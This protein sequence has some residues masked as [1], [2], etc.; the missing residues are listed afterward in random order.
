MVQLI[1]LFKDSYRRRKWQP[2]PVLLPGEFHGWRNFVDY[3]PEG[4]KELDT[5][6][7]VSEWAQDIIAKEEMLRPRNEQVLRAE[8]R[9]PTMAQKRNEKNLGSCGHYWVKK[10]SSSPKLLMGKICFS[11]FK[12]V[13]WWL[14]HLTDTGIRET[15]F[16]SFLECVSVCVHSVVSDFLQ[17]HGLQPAELLYPWDSPGKNTGEGCLVLL[18]GIFLTQG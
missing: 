16:T 8:I 14:K 18:H 2:T 3:S 13:Y 17:P 11:L 6:E 7:Q 4:H 15:N 10:L 1:S 9:N 5:I 12:P